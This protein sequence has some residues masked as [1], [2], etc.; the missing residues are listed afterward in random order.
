LQLH[1][2]LHR[3]KVGARDN[4]DMRRVQQARNPPALPCRERLKFLTAPFDRPL[5]C[6]TTIACGA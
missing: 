5:R 3:V 2:F 6:G 4:M 1:L